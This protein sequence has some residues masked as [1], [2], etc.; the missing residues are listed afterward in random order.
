[1]R[2]HCDVTR[3]FMEPVEALGISG[4]AALSALPAY[5]FWASSDRG[6][7]QLGAASGFVH[8]KVSAGPGNAT[9]PRA[10][11]KSMIV[12]GKGALVTRPPPPNPPPPGPGG[13]NSKGKWSHVPE[14]D[15]PGGFRG[16]VSHQLPCHY[17]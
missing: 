7:G 15:P 14:S 11:S 2:C 9:R 8:N 16:G 12:A 17:R 6:S 5:L 13:Q 4:R 10:P 3:D 1:M